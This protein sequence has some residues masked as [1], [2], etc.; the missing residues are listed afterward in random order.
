[1]AAWSHGAEIELVALPSGPRR[2][3][4]TSSAY[5]AST[6]TP[7]GVNRCRRTC[8]NAASTAGEVIAP[9]ASS[10][11]TSRARAVSVSSVSSG[12]AIVGSLRFGRSAR[13]FIPD[14]VGPRSW[15]VG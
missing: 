10:L 2:V 3:T 15:G 8:L 6:L 1:M 5:A 4:T 11:S 9:S 12:S 13:E 14:L 7:E